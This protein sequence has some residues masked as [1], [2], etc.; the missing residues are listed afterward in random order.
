MA[1]GPE[2]GLVPGRD[3]E[4]VADHRDGKREGQRVD[5]VEA[6][7]GIEWRQEPAGGVTDPRLEAG[8]RP[9][10]ERAGHEPPEAGVAG[11]VHR[12]HVGGGKLG[13]RIAGRVGPRPVSAQVQG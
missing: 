1:A 5:E 13:A 11:R 2:A 4:K 9:W 12:E 3:A 6:R 7:R 10:G 8:Y